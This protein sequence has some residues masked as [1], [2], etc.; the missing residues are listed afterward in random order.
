MAALSSA[1]RSLPN[2]TAARRDLFDD[3]L[4]TVCHE[5]TDSNGGAELRKR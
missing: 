3:P 4:T 1:A 2:V 5:R